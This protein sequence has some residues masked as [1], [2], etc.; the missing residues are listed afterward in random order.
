MADLF[1]R[2]KQ[3]AKKHFPLGEANINHANFVIELGP[4]SE[5]PSRERWDGKDVLVY[6]YED[7]LVIKISS[8]KDFRKSLGTPKPGQYTKSFEGFKKFVD[9][10]R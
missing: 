1:D 10:L 3:Y 5:R 2:A 4:S 6:Q 7:V 8:R 9:A